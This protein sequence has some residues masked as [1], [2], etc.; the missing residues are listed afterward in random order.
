MIRARA[1]LFDLDGVLVDSRDAVAWVWRDWA[2]PRGLDPEPFIRVAHGRRISETLR[3]VAPRLDIAAET[4]ALDALEEAETRGLAPA[5][6][7]SEL[8]GRIEPGRWGIVTSGSRAVATLRLRAAAIAPPAVFITADDVAAG[9]P[10]PEGYLAAASRL[11][12]LP[13]ECVVIEDSPPGVAA[14]KAAGM[15]VIAVAT[16]HPPDALAA[17]DLCLPD[18]THAR[19]TVTSAGVVLGEWA[20]A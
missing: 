9:K 16:T 19:V 17:A 8:L 3:L 2:A 11:A 15:T 14:G 6:G 20:A 13:A 10:D 4:A 1:I 12:A 7:A 5:P 18:L